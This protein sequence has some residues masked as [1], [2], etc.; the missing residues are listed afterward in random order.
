[1]VDDTRTR[2]L[3]LIETQDRENAKL[4]ERHPDLRGIHQ[5]Q[6]G[7]SINSEA[8][9]NCTQAAVA[10]LMGLNLDDV[11]HFVELTLGDPRGGAWAHVLHTWSSDRFGIG[12]IGV[13]PSSILR[14]PFN[15]PRSDVLLL[16]GGPS[17]RGPWGHSVVVDANLELVWD[18]NPGGEGVKYVQSL[19]VPVIAEPSGHDDDGEPLYTIV[20]LPYAALA[21][22]S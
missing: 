6:F 12:W 15:V 7:T 8:P 21:V 22:H 5:T 2:I 17:P 1:M 9:G 11:P 16:G 20:K 14:H 3:E 18:P 10:T 13:E 19:D 4:R